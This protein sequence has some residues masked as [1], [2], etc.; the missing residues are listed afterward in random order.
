MTV[1]V[2]M[3]SLKPFLDMRIEEMKKDTADTVKNSRDSQQDNLFG[4][5]M[6]AALHAVAYFYT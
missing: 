3:P 2:T 1:N 4:L 5:K 6:D